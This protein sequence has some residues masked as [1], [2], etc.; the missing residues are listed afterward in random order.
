M[1]ISDMFRGVPS[2][3]ITF[4][5]YDEVAHHSGIDRPDALKV[6][7]RLD[8]VIGHIERT[9]SQA[10]RPYRLVVLSDHGQSMGAT[11]KQRYD[12]TLGE[13]V[14]ELVSK[15][16][17]V[18]A[19]EA[20][21]EALGQINAAIAQ[22]MQTD[23][24]TSRLVR[25]AVQGHMQEGELTIGAEQETMPQVANVVGNA[26]DIVVLASGNLG[27]ISFTR[28]PERL[29]YEQLV[30]KYPELVPGL[31]NHPG[32]SFI[33]VHS[34]D[35]GGL[36]IGEG[37]VHYLDHGYAAGNDP[38]AGF[39]PRA[40]AH[41]KRTDGFPNAPDILVISMVDH[42]TGEVAAFEE[43]VGCHGGLG[44]T[45]T[46]PFVFYPSDLP[47]EPGHEIVGAGGLHDVL[48]SW[49]DHLQPAAEPA[50]ADPVHA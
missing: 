24:R 3:Y 16:T 45:Q 8:G 4:F 41:L 35:E 5:A 47:L 9:S 39:G 49:V 1:L 19:P 17:R 34:A 11:F 48:V 29:T 42:R 44:G 12:K 50:G 20:A 46:Q 15:E 37:G 10:S 7:K 14:D 23:S 40:A 6:L 13:L 32:I 22:A 36:V 18:V 21:D 43:L 25:R 28:E 27:L 30:D 2:V 38:L 33:L 31:I 26:S